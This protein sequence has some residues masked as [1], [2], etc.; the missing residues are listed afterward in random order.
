MENY[1]KAG[2]DIAQSNK[3]TDWIKQKVKTKYGSRVVSGVGG[4]S[5]LYKITSEKM[6]SVG[7]DGVGTKLI[8]AQKFNQHHTIGIDLVAMCA[9]DILCCNATP[10]FF[11]DYLACGKINMDIA[12]N[13]ID[14]I[15]K[16]C[17]QS[18]CAL[19]GGETAEMPDFYSN[20]K[21]DLAGFAVG[22]VNAEDLITGK[23]V[24]SGQSIIALASSGFHSNGY[25]LLRHLCKED[26][27]FLQQSLTP[28]K[29][30]VSIIKKLV[31]KVGF[32]SIKGLAHCT[33]EGV[34][35]I[36]RIH[37]NFDYHLNTV[38]DYHDEDFKKNVSPLFSILCEK[39]PLDKKELYNVFNMGMGFFIITDKE[40]DILREL[41]NL[42]E[43]A[44]KVGTVSKGTGRVLI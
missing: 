37:P 24:S 21:Y 9:N 33:G 32:P 43:I 14:G 35:N 12:K 30:Y 15:Q 2:V 10:L 34:Q 29:I 11:M 4:F 8:L 7:A 19:I 39:H 13:I 31:K 42:G 38:P 25:S 22:E 28:T 20:N 41:K 36:A 23:K 5:A 27:D 17:E 1:K 6:L 26:D 40:E 18:E 44:W 16:G 3:F